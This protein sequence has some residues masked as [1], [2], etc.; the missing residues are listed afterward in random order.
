[1]T[2]A[3]ARP[4]PRS[5]STSWIP[6]STPSSQAMPATPPP[7]RTSARF[8]VCQRPGPCLHTN[9]PHAGCRATL[10]RG[11]DEKPGGAAGRARRGQRRVGAV[12][13][14]GLAL[15]DPCRRA[16]FLTLIAITGL[17]ALA[18]DFFV[19]GISV[20]FLAQL[21]APPWLPGTA[22]ALLTGLTSL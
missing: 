1:M 14:R 5:G 19:T 2:S 17:V 20:Y 22:L 9:R 4:D 13:A 11:H 10:G 16:P 6:R 7:A 15:R 12:P 21:H 18:A 3:A 8:T